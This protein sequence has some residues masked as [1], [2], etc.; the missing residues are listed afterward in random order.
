M[1]MR[2]VSFQLGG[3]M[4]PAES[5]ERTVEM[6][7]LICVFNIDREGSHGA[8]SIKTDIY[9]SLGWLWFAANSKWTQDYGRTRATF[10]NKPQV[11]LSNIR[12]VPT[13]SPDPRDSFIVSF[14]CPRCNQT[15]TRFLVEYGLNAPCHMPNTP[16]WRCG[17]MS[18]N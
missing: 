15:Q 3:K 1:R 13:G 10:Q 14:F 11:S 2:S 6:N 8:R 18:V 7:A 5:T 16:K 12:P 9:Y 4:A 17:F